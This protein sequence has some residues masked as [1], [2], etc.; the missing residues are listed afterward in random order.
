MTDLLLTCGGCHTPVEI[1]AESA[2]LSRDVAPSLAGELLFRCPACGTAAVQPID[3]D[4]LIQLL[5]V[6]IHP[7]AIGE[8]TLEACARPQTGARFEWEDLLDWHQQL[9]DVSFVVPWE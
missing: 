9:D 5:F 2:V 4:A 8:P 7:L 3:A 6:G 1:R